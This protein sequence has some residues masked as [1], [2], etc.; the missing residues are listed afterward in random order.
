MI[1]E[2]ALFLFLAFFLVVGLLVAATVTPY[3]VS[4]IVS[5]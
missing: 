1:K 3:L 4:S 5:S 2:I